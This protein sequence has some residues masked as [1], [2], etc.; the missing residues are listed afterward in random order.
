MEKVYF[1]AEINKWVVKDLSDFYSFKCSQGGEEKKLIL[2]WTKVTEEDNIAEADVRLYMVDVDDVK[3]RL[4]L[5][6]DDSISKI[7]KFILSPL[8]YEM[9]LIGL[10]FIGETEI[11]NPDK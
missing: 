10:S 1:D 8:D 5:R 7:G 11:E 9:D 2:T 6:Y 4:I 3:I